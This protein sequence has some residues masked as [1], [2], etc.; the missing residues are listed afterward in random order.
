MTLPT[1]EAQIKR[2]KQLADDGFGEFL[3]EYRAL[4]GQRCVGI[5]TADPDRCVDEA[6]TRTLWPV[7]VY[8][9]GAQSVVCWPNVDYHA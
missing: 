9:A 2:I 7:N 3:P 6:K 1:K 5:Q 4:H 8:L